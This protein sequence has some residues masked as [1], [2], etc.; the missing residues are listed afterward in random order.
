[1]RQDH[2]V[3]R[4]FPESDWRVL[5][6]LRSRALQRLCERALGEIR[7]ASLAADKTAHE[8]FLAVYKLVRERNEDVA[9][10]FDDPRRSRAFFQLAVMKSLGLIEEEE[11][12]RFS[13]GVLETLSV[14]LRDDQ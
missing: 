9:R 13:A 8:R 2:E 14:L 12:K 4:D 5:R 6:E 7:D 1:L 11:L 10:G 3:A